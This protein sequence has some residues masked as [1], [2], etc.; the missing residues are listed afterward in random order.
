MQNYIKG[1]G[2]LVGAFNEDDLKQSKDKAQVKKMKEETG[3]QY[4][5]TEFVKKNG[6]IV[7]MKV[8]VCTLDDMRVDV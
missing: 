5:N 7:A 8:Y 2:I 6:K 4:T 3:Y 1:K